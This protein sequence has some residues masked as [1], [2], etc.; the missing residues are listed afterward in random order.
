MGIRWHSSIFSIMETKFLIILI[1][2]R[3]DED[4]CSQLCKQ[5]I[6]FWN[7][8]VILYVNMLKLKDII[9]KI[10]C[11]HKLSFQ[12]TL[13][14]DESEKYRGKNE[15]L[16]TFIKERFFSSAWTKHLH[17]FLHQSIIPFRVFRGISRKTYWPVQNDGFI[18]MSIIPVCFAMSVSTRK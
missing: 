12:I 6:L 4:N 16:E 13:F 1:N 2:C 11:K 14:D 15:G 7:A 5:D 9:K 18:R 3:D 17:I 8:I 10:V